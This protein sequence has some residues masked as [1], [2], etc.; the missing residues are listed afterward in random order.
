VH[1]CAGGTSVS[2]PVQVLVELMF[3]AVELM[4]FAVELLCSALAPP[5][6]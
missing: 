5:W 2:A 3:S 4:C 6:E 1:L